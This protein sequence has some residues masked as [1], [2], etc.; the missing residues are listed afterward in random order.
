MLELI[1]LLALIYV[2]FKFGG[3]ILGFVAKCILAFLLLAF[4]IP[5]LW[6]LLQFVMAFTAAFWLM[7]FTL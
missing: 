6:V 2:A 7:I 1:G 3:S 4:F 5:V